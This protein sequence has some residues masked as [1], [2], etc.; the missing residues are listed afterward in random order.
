MSA[1][2][3]LC[4]Y[5]YTSMTNGL[6]HILCEAE[7]HTIPK[8]WENW[9]W[10]VQGKVRAK[11]RNI[12]KLWVSLIYSVKQKSIPFPNHGKVNSLLENYGKTKN[13]SKTWVSYKLNI[14]CEAEIHSFLQFQKHGKSEFH[15]I[16]K[17]YGKTKKIQPNLRF[18]TY[19]TGSK[20]P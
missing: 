19:L 1:L 9:I 20:N 12:P 8:T 7:T 2:L 17:K 5:F 10:V 13:I 16:R 11:M 15:I 14:L 3:V 18:F 6:L 4:I